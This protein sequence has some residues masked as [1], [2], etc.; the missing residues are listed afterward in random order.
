MSNDDEDVL[1]I[2]VATDNHLGKIYTLSLSRRS[3]KIDARKTAGYLEN[4]PVR[5]W[6]SFVAFEEILKLGAEKEVDLILLGGDLFHHNK[7]SRQTMHRT[8]A[9]FRK[10][11]L[12]EG[13]VRIQIVSDQKLNFKANGGRV[14]FEDPNFAVQMPVF[15]IH[16]NH[17]DPTRNGGSGSLSAVDLVAACNLINY[18]GKSETVDNV[19]IAPVLIKKG[20][21]KVALYGLGNVR[22]ERLNRAWTQ[23]NVKFV[24]PED[25]TD[26]WFNI[27]TLHQNRDYGRGKKNCIHEHMLPEFLDLV[28]WGHEH[29]C[30]IKPQWS[31]NEAFAV[32]SSIHHLLHTIITLKHQRTRNTG[33]STWIFCCDVSFGR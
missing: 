15:T 25:G 27:F 13:A 21:T 30:I 28:I 6:D 5:G 12:G 7:P 10:Y 17:D 8:I 32:R 9:M 31:T 23:K 2:L 29:E 4:D 11:C 33:T 24:T 22:D 1:R 18:F 19:E 26:D 20:E 14:N 16:G 3:L